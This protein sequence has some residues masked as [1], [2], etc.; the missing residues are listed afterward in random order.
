MPNQGAGSTTSY[1]NSTGS[2]VT[3]STAEYN[4]LEVGQYIWLAVLAIVA[5]L[6]SVFVVESGRHLRK[7]SNRKLC[8]ISAI[9]SIVSFSMLWLLYA[10]VSIIIIGFILALI[11]SV[12]NFLYA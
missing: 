3:T 11:G 10:D 12:L 2:S 9:S 5:V 4:Q 8:L 1:Y 7:T 6:F